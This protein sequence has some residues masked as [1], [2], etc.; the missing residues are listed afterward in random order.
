[1]LVG[2]IGKFYQK[3]IEIFEVTDFS[4]YI[5]GNNIDSKFDDYER[6]E[7]FGFFNP[8]NGTYHFCYKLISYEIDS[9]YDIEK[10]YIHNLYKKYTHIDLLNCL[11]VWIGELDGHFNY[12]IFFC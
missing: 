5:I 6:K 9:L 10:E 3:E 2:K 11:Y 12:E 4:A 8:E 1:M 7:Y